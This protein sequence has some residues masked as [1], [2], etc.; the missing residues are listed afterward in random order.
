MISGTTGS[1][2][3]VDIAYE[4]RKNRKKKL[5]RI[6]DESKENSK[7][8]IIDKWKPIIDSL[9]ISDDKKNWMNKYAEFNHLH[10]KEF[11]LSYDRNIIGELDTTQDNLS[12]NTTTFNEFTTFLPIAMKVSAHTI[13]NGGYYESDERIKKRERTQKLKKILGD[14]EFSNI[15]SDESYDEIMTV[16]KEEYYGGLVSVSPMNYPTPTLMYMNFVYDTSESDKQ[17]AERI[18]K[19]RQEK[20]G[21]ILYEL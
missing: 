8:S 18:R 15:V 2:E 10:E 14:T 13:G 12:Q 11:D 20:L 4:K 6:I 21:R 1:F 16:K 17:K 19:N 7:N 9:N 5:K 3:Y